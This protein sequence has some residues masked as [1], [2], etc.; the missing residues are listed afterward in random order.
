MRALDDT[1]IDPEIAAELDAIDAT[2]TGEPVDPKYADIA[3][4]ALLLVAERPAPSDAFLSSLDARAERRFAPAPG[5]SRTATAGGGVWQ[6][7]WSLGTMPVFGTAA[8]GL[9]A[10]VVAIVVLTSGGSNRHDVVDALNLSPSLPNSGV[11]LPS[12][13]TSAGAAKKIGKP[14]VLGPGT[15]TSSATTASPSTPSSGSS[16]SAA[17]SWGGAA[18]TAGGASTAA[19]TTPSTP[20]APANGPS[21]AESL[22]AAPAP[23]G[24]AALG[25]IATPAP[26]SNGRK[27]VQSAQIALSTR[28]RHID[29]VSQE[30]FNVVGKENGI[31]ERSNVTSS[32]R[33]DSYAQFQLSIPSG[34]LTATLNQLSRLQYA[35]VGS[36]SDSTEDIN[37]A[38]VSARSTL[39]EQQALRTSLLKQL[40]AA[41]T[42]QAIESIKG[43]LHG[44]DLKIAA[45]QAQLKNLNH[46]VAYSQVQVT[47]NGSQR[48]VP[49][50]HHSSMNR[51]FTLGK[52]LHDAGRVLTVVAGVALISLAVLLPVGLLTAL[53]GWIGFGVRRRRREHALD[54]A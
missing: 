7:L 37:H 27:I 47:I 3:E 48:P 17:S 51:G 52:A 26:Q 9:A 6:R 28:P 11:A 25:A 29:D 41:Y 20:H 54:L 16:S 21:K 14:A 12:P 45:L 32:G 4:L 50:N 49:T 30:V 43:R 13:G 10:A 39:A 24:S 33:P 40:A 22:A 19:T 5:E 44:V 53:A 23:T 15:A 35:H 46:R 2:L 1:P 31:V 36:R 38:F 42:T 18:G 34:N 8:A